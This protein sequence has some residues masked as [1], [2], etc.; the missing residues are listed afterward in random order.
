MT[1]FRDPAPRVYAVAPGADFA[2]GFA[3][4]LWGIRNPKGAAD[5]ISALQG[6]RQAEGWS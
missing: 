2:T 5:A 3:D 6:E 1:L 4:G